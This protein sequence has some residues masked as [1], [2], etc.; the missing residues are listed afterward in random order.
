MFVNAATQ[1][2]KT[3]SCAAERKAAVGAIRSRL[4]RGYDQVAGRT[5]LMHLQ[6]DL[7]CW[8]ARRS[9]SPLYFNRLPSP[10]KAG[11]LRDMSGMLKRL[12]ICV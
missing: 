1:L 8:R 4:D 5:S 12:A 3:I 7:L 10:N 11:V 9:I 6:H 2:S